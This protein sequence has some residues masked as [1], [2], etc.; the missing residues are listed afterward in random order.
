MVKKMFKKQNDDDIDAQVQANALSSNS[1]FISEK[2]E[3]GTDLIKALVEQ[4][5]ETGAV[6]LKNVANTTG[7][8]NEP[9]LEI[10]KTKLMLGKFIIN[11]CM[12]PRFMKKGKEDFISELADDISLNIALSKNRRGGF[13]KSFTQQVRKIFTAKSKKGEE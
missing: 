3:Y 2:T 6:A 9:E 13:L 5:S 1:Q 11:E 7:C 8:L 4:Y 10:G 12:F